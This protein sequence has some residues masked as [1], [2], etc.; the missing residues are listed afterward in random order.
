M[1]RFVKNILTLCILSAC[2]SSFASSSVAMAPAG[3]VKRLY[4]STR[5]TTQ[6]AAEMDAMEYC[7]KV[8][9]MDGHTGE[10]KIVGSMDEYSFVAIA[11]AKNG[12]GFGYSI[13]TDL[14]SAFRKAYQGCIESNPG[15]CDDFVRVH[16]NG[17]ILIKDMSSDQRAKAPSNR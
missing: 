10:C 6:K 3:D 5:T 14:Q 15:G 13:N 7:K 2:A 16:I 11:Y 9:H 1:P 8:R 4:V 17:E 12:V